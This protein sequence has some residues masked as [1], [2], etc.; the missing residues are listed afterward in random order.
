LLPAVVVPVISVE[1]ASVPTKR[2][3][4][5]EPPAAYINGK[6]GRVSL[7]VLFAD[8]RPF[9]IT[10]VAPPP[11]PNPKFALAA[12]ELEFPPP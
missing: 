4:P 1:D 3:L 5:P 11:P 8:I 9:L 6:P 7:N 2:V 10:M 12:N